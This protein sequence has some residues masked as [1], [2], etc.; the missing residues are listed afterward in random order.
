MISATASLSGQMAPALIESLGAFDTYGAVG[1][2]DLALSPVVHV[3]INFTQATVTGDP[4][5]TSTAALH[6]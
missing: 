3:L 2:L 1:T 5:L 6:F 4:F